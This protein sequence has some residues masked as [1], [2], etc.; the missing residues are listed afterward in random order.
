MAFKRA[1]IPGSVF[2]L[3]GGAGAEVGG[4]ELHGIGTSSAPKEFEEK[5]RFTLPRPD[6]DRLEVAIV[7]SR[8]N[9]KACTDEMVANHRML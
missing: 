3:A 2:V 4:L 1:S 6:M 9:D 7:V 8:M 5:S